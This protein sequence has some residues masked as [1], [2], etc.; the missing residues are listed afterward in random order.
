MGKKLMLLKGMARQ[1]GVFMAQVNE[2][3]TLSPFYGAILYEVFDGKGVKPLHQMKRREMGY[4]VVSTPT[5]PR[6]WMGDV[7]LCLEDSR[8]F[9]VVGRDT[10]LN[11]LRVRANRWVRQL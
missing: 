8:R 5:L 9:S 10:L 7:V 1:K 6:Y 4:L 3:P 2:K 11:R